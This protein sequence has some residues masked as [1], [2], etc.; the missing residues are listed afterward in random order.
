M[1]DEEDVT[2]NDDNICNEIVNGEQDVV[3]ITCDYKSRDLP[4]LRGR[5]VTIRR[6]ENVPFRH[7][8]NFC[9]VEVL[10]CHPGFWGKD[11]ESGDCSRSCGHC[12]EQTCRLSD[13]H[14]YTRCQ[15]H[16]WG[17]NCINRCNCQDCDR[18]TGCPTVG[19][20]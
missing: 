11:L 13:G 17:D 8:M 5:Y 2:P 14:C 10:S 18:S 1:G 6:K 3:S 19:E 20:S 7:L 12:A 15:D 16:Y 9:E 4:H